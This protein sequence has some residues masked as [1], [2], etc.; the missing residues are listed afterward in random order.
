MRHALLLLFVLAI[1]SSRTFGA[2]VD[3][4]KAQKLFERA[5]FDY[6]QGR[7][8]ESVKVYK[9]LVRKYPDSAA[10]QI[11]AQRCAP[12]AVLGTHKLLEH[13]PPANRVD[14]A[15]M[16]DGFTIHR[17][18]TFDKWAADIPAVFE[19]Q[20]LFDEYFG[21]LNFHTFHIVS[22][23][24]NVDGYGRE[25]STALGGLTQNTVQ[26]HV[27]VDNRLVRAALDSLPEH[28]GLALV[29]VRAGILGSASSGIAAIGGRDAGTTIH[30]WGHA[31]AGLGD[32]YS[33]FTHDRGSARVA[34]NLSLTDDEEELPWAH[35]I[36]AR[37][38]GVGA[39]EGGAG[40]ERGVWR[41]T[42][43]DCVMLRGEFFCPPCREGLILRIYSLVDPIDSTNYP[44][45][46]FEHPASLILEEEF[47]FEVTV[48]QPKS[49]NLEVSWWLF[50]EASAP[51]PLKPSDPRYVRPVPKR[52][53]RNDRGPLPAIE[54]EPRASSAINKSGVHRL[55]IK[56]KDLEPGRYRLIC[57][58]KDSTQLRGE[59]LP[60]VLRD[61]RG[62]LESERA[63]WIQV[64]ER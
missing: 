22:A 30:E 7:Y 58:A 4:E 45:H 51:Q 60:W 48:M 37:A 3:E 2:G 13:G 28:D 54:A 56:S 19:H 64:G 14:I 41:P 29:Y 40:Q 53:D 50:P 59:R 39:Y 33:T 31:F 15:L 34:I 44:A 61:D 8:S 55:V 42:A 21:Y 63:W 23:D 10:A 43:S 62:L 6:E 20:L 26:G 5:V 36:E 1:I 49:H 25:E 27:G 57:R 35:W 24:S 11:A 47:E 38:K 12:N 32:E 46:P 18:D 16:G 9:L 52:G 17:Q